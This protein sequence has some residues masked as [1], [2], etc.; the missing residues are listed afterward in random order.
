MTWM[1]IAGSVRVSRTLQYTCQIA[2]MSLQYG[3]LPLN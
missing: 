2:A 3:T 1:C